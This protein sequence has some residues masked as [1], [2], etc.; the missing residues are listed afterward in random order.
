MA[1]AQPVAVQH[2]EEDAIP[3]R[4]I[5]PGDLSA[6]LIQ[7]WRDFMAIPTQLLFLSV[8]YPVI[9]LVAARVASGGPMLPLLWP[10]IAGFALVGPVTAL[11]LCEISRRRER[12]LP[13]AWY[14]AFDVFRSPSLVPI[15]CVTAALAGL[16][17][18]W[19]IAARIVWNG[20]MDRFE[21]HSIEELLGRV[22]HTTEGWWLIAIGN[23]VGLLF[24]LLV[25]ATTLITFPVLI[26]RGIAPER[27]VGLS[28]RATARNPVMVLLW[29]LVVAVTLFIA[30]IPAFLGIAIAVPVLGH[31]TWHLYRRLVP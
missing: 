1:T 9:G 21:P 18:A 3:V 25:L 11:G 24:A 19:L 10:L 13:T 2:A 20:T 22:L 28:L 29:G 14:N 15:L 12:M 27:A 6:A 4:R 17:V 26:D 23:G 8:L 5:G 7:G 16:F 30:S 31:A